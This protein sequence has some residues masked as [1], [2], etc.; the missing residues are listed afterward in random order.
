M[1]RVR[2][3]FP[4]PK[5]WHT[6]N[7]THTVISGTFIVECEGQRATLGAGSFNFMPSRM[8]HEAWTT[9]EE[10]ALLFITVDKAWDINW[11]GGTPAPTDF[12]PGRPR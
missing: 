11:V 1:I 8:P 10:G 2:E 4:A 9:P 3:N 5:H 7:E 12:S 6:A